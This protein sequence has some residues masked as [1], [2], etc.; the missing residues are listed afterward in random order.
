MVTKTAS[1]ETVSPVTAVRRLRVAV[2]SD[3][4]FST[5]GI[6]VFLQQLLARTAGQLDAQLVTWSAEPP[7]PDEVELTL[8]QHGDVRPLWDAIAAADVTLLLTSFNVRALAWLAADCLAALST[9]SVVVVHTSEHSSP[10]F[11]GFWMRGD[12][13]I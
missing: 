13:S 6:E 12:P 4:D 1:P 2:V 10:G 8:I 7:V 3:Y 11:T 5:G 9:P